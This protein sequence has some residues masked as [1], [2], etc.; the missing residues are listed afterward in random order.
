MWALESKRH[1]QGVFSCVMQFVFAQAKG[2]ACSL[3]VNGTIKCDRD[4][5]V[6]KS[7]ENLEIIRGGFTCRSAD[8]DSGPGYKVYASHSCG[9]VDENSFVPLFRL[10]AF[11]MASS[12]FVSPTPLPHDRP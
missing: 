11:P 2:F 3:H 1:V 10:C 4:C 9:L 6:A 12:K 7:T 5:F 8:P